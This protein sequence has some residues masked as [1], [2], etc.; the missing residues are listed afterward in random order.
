MWQIARQLTK[1]DSRVGFGN[2]AGRVSDG[3][4]LAIASSECDSTGSHVL[5]ISLEAQS[6]EARLAD[7]HPI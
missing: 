5:V 2:Q 4:A 7:H 1:T 3:A 6:V